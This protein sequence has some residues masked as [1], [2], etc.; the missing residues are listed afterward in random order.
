MLRM[1]RRINTAHMVLG[2]LIINLCLV[3]TIT[4]AHAIGLKHNSV[5]DRH[6]LRLSDVF[7]DLPEGKDK[8]I[9]SA[10]GPGDDLTLKART[11]LRLALSTNLD[12]RP[13]SSG[14]YVTIRRAATIVGSDD[15][16]DV[17]K[18]SLRDHGMTGHYNV[19]LPQG[20]N[21]IVLPSDMPGRVVVKDMRV[22]PV[23][24][25]F[26]ATLVAPSID[27]PI[28][29]LQVRGH[30]ERLTA[31]PVLKETLK[32]G[33]VIGKN[34]I[35]FMYLQDHMVRG[36]LAL[37][38]DHLIGMTPR[39]IVTAGQ[40]VEM[41]ELETRK[42]VERGEMVTMIFQR[43]ALQLTAQGKALQ[44]GAKGD[45]VRVVNMGSNKTLQAHVSGEREV[46]V[47]SF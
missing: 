46:T 1:L 29:S 18:T 44:N 4:Y 33:D 21:R 2:L 14:D 10:P 16:Q 5:V 28:Q 3:M 42:V 41:N 20:P 38:A 35:D 39:R 8:V 36:D 24:Q 34:D 9:G 32:N 17:L 45:I 30:V 19:L 27:N 6:D 40:P 12:W 26:E 15:I 43:G 11:L 47:Q 22:D 23:Q 13:G 7:Y 37:K 25:I 31:V